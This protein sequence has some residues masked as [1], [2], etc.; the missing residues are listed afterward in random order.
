MERDGT[1]QFLPFSTICHLIR[2]LGRPAPCRP[3]EP[4]PTRPFPGPPSAWSSPGDPVTAAPHPD[5]PP[6][7]DA[8]RRGRRGPRPSR[9]AGPATPAGPRSALRR[10]D[11]RRTGPAHR[12]PRTAPR[13]PAPPR[14]PPPPG[15][16][17]AAPVG[18]VRGAGEHRT[19]RGDPR[20]RELAAGV[21]AGRGMDAR[22]LPEDGAGTERPGCR[23]PIGGTR[24]GSGSCSPCS[25]PHPP[26]PQLSTIAALFGRERCHVW[27]PHGRAGSL[28]ASHRMDARPGGT[29]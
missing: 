1:S 13:T 12:R 20:R 6:A 7:G 23:S 10:P 27:S 16:V 5:L 11:A 2:P 25:D 17:R 26:R 28:A 14:P 29:R 22:A 9:T 21:R 18:R 8:A 15:Q 24:G 3:P 19:G 4:G